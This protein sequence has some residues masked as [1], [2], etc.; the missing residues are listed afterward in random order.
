MAK[1]GS[2]IL[3]TVTQQHAASFCVTKHSQT[4]WFTYPVL[5][6]IKTASHK[7]PPQFL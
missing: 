5:N 6:Q 7:K 2:V 1:K 4:R 3:G